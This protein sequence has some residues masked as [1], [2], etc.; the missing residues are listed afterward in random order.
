MTHFRQ[1]L[2]APTEDVNF[3]I[4]KMKSLPSGG[5]LAS[6]FNIFEQYGVAAVGKAMKPWSLSP[7]KPFPS[8]SNASLLQ[9]ITGVKVVSDLGTLTTSLQGPVDRTQ[10]Y[11]SWGLIE[12]GEY[13]GKTFRFHPFMTVRN[14]FL[15]FMMHFGIAFGSLM[16]A[17]P[18]VRWLLKRM[19]Y[20]PGEGA[21]KE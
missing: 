11:R 12:G 15:G 9:L 4:H 6:V 17:L 3:T 8:K 5:T 1:T 19:V 13:Y 2:G 20:Q 7:I 14:I 16:L 10:V 18:P 21:A